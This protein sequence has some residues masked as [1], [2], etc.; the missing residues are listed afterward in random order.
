MDYSV[1]AG[2][3]VTF[4]FLLLG[5]ESVIPP[6]KRPIPKASLGLYGLGNAVWLSLGITMNNSALVLISSLQLLFISY[7]IASCNIRFFL[8]VIY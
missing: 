6:T 4:S 5:I 2:A 7:V 3:L 1:L 8:Q